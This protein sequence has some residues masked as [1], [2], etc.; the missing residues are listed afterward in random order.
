MPSTKLQKSLLEEIKELFAK[1]F[2]HQDTINLKEN[3]TASKTR[4]DKLLDVI[5]SLCG[6]NIDIQDKFNIHTQILNNLKEKDVAEFFHKRNNTQL[7]S[8]SSVNN[9][10]ASFDQI[11]GIRS[12]AVVE[13]PEAV[14]NNSQKIHHKKE[15]YF[16]INNDEKIGKF[17]NKISKILTKNLYGYSSSDE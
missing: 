12:G 7:E 1:Y 4:E 8:D 11:H 9:N 10:R 13:D 16:R 5:K 6:K 2:K 3:W 14:A 15:S 17:I